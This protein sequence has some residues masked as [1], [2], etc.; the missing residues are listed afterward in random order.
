M[1]NGERVEEKKERHR[2]S[3]KDRLRERWGEIENRYNQF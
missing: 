2:E 1:R 3:V